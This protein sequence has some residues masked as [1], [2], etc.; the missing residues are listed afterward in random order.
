MITVTVTVITIR[1]GDIMIGRGDP[2]RRR[3]ITTTVEPNMQAL[4]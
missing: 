2:L 1:P 3:Q 4:W